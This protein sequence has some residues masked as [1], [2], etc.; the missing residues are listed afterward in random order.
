MCVMLSHFLG[1]YWGMRDV[2]SSYTSSPLQEGPN[3][4]LFMFV[5]FSYFNYGAFG[6]ALFFL[7]SGFVI[8]FTLEKSHPLTFFVARFFRIFP[9]YVVCLALGLLAVKASGHYWGRSFPWDLK[10][11][12]SNMLLI[13]EYIGLPSVDLVNWSLVIELCFYVVAAILAPVIRKGR[14]LPILFFGL[15]S[16][17]AN[18]IGSNAIHEMAMRMVFIGYMF[19]GTFFWYAI[20]NRINFRTLV[21]ASLLQFAMFA[22]AWSFSI[23]ADQYPVITLNY[24]YALIVFA[25]LFAF[26]HLLQPNRLLDFMADISYPFYIMHSLIG[27]SIIRFLIDQGVPFYRGSFFALCFVCVISYAVHRIVEL[28][29]I[30]FGKQLTRKYTPRLP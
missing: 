16:I 21:V 28:P 8:P 2:V 20:T 26:R 7:V 23:R 15:V 18:F 6:V 30:T 12:V 25:L 27:Y 5:S 4:A 22:F 10:T 1:V 9:T 24:L 29:S 3:S 19:I 11:V 14:L 13:H 17:A